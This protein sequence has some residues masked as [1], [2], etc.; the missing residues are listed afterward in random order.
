MSPILPQRRL[1]G[2]AD[3]EHE[4]LQRIANVLGRVRT[5]RNELRRLGATQAADYL[6]RAIKSIEGA[7][8]HAHRCYSDAY[9]TARRQEGTA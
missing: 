6:A 4:R 7:E 3:E 9:Y 8:R 1:L 2:T 5:A